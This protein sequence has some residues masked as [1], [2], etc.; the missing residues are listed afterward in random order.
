M[1]EEKMGQNNEEL[2]VIDF[3]V[4][5]LD[6]EEYDDTEYVEDY[7]EESSYNNENMPK[8]SMF[9]RA[10][11]FVSD[12]TEPAPAKETA[13]FGE[14][15]NEVGEKNTFIEKFKVLISEPRS[16]AL[17]SLF[18]WMIF[19]I[20]VI[21]LVRGGVSDTTPLQDET[22]NETSS[23]EYS[24]LDNYAYSMT[25]L[26]QNA[27]KILDGK[28]FNGKTIFTLDNVSYYVENGAISEIK[29]NAL[30]TSNLELEIDYN[31][32]TPKG[33]SEI[34]DKAEIIENSTD[35]KGNITGNTYSISAKE[36]L[37]YLYN[38][39]VDTD[40][41]VMISV[42]YEGK[43]VSYIEI[44]MSEIIDLEPSDKIVSEIAVTYM[45]IGNVTEYDVTYDAEET[46]E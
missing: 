43:N 2:E 13:T 46:N 37:L 22:N 18:G 8:K 23:T 29:D 36:L 31:K 35:V 40:K 28:S 4:D 14:I 16:K 42:R 44:N 34:L 38:I 20:I 41:E 21:M 24:R 1:E 32:L 30:E 25:L 10:Q 9:N 5:D 27:T 19:M 17:L 33:L 7:E 11:D 39:D 3:D 45:G 15:F 6:E 26:T 12:F